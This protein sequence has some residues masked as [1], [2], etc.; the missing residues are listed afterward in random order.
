MSPEDRLAWGLTNRWRC[1]AALTSTLL[2]APAM[3]EDQVR[4]TGSTTADE[5]LINDVF[6]S[7]AHYVLER[8]KCQNI[9]LIEADVLPDGAVKRDASLPEG[10]GPATYEQWTVTYCGK[11]LPFLVV[12]WDAKEGGTMYRVQLRPQPD[13]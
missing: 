11:K 8:L 6:Q 7:I 1:L 5:K 9:E 4:F 3:A 12:F 10:T 13:S 2:M